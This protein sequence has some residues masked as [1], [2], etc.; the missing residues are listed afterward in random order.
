MAR[1]GQSRLTRLISCRLTS[2]GRSVISSIL[3]KPAMRGAAILDRAVARG[4]VDHRRVLAQRLPDHAAP[5]GLEGADDVVFLV[6]R[7]GARRARTGWA[8]SRR[9]CC[10]VGRP[11]LS[12]SAH[13]EA[14]GSSGP[15]SCRPRRRPR[16]DPGPGATASPPAQ[17][18]GSE[19]RPL[20]ID[21]DLAALERRAARRH[22][23]ARPAASCWPI[24]L[25][26]MS[27]RSVKSSPVPARRPGA[28]ARVCSSS[29]ARTWPSIAEQPRRPHPVA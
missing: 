29:T 9:R 18:P 24:A 10:S 2:S 6:G 14:R 5:A 3:L 13:Q 12:P 25:N 21:A 1:S 26:T 28:S 23:R 8:P 22:R 17:T 19:V 15:R 20:G 4:D 16:S 27:A 7:R 11:W